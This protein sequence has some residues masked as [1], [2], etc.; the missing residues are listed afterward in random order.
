MVLVT[1]GEHDAADVADT[2]MQ[3]LD[4]RNHQF[5]ARHLLL[6]EHQAGVDDD[7][8][9]AP[10]ER[11]H[12]AADLAEPPQRDK[13]QLSRPDR[14]GQKRSI[15]SPPG[16]ATASRNSDAVAPPARR[17]RVASASLR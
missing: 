14:V 4:V 15:W 12:V 8:V 1:V 16:A 11:E 7:D 9:V 3:Q 2:F 10:A 17:A 13:G 5:H 6:G